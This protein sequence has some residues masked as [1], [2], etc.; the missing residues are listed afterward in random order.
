MSL[1]AHPVLPYHRRARRLA[2]AWS[3]E[4]TSYDCHV[5]GHSANHAQRDAES[6]EVYSGVFPTIHQL[7]ETGRSLQEIANALNSQG[8]TTL[9]GAAWNRMQVNRL[10]AK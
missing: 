4:R 9:R 6:D 2:R 8:H 1:A 3:D 10:L 7:R 5:Y